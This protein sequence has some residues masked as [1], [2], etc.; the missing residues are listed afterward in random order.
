MVWILLE[1]GAVGTFCSGAAAS[2]SAHGRTHVNSIYDGQM[3]YSPVLRS[4]LA[5]LKSPPPVT[6]SERNSTLWPFMASAL[7]KNAGGQ[8]VGWRKLLKREMEDVKGKKLEKLT[9]APT[10]DFWLSKQLADA[11]TALGAGLL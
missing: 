6:D 11:A 3:K 4:K 8:A 10:F 7:A 5:D 2:T 9:L 1:V